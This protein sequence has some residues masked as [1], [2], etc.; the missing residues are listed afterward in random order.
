MLDCSSHRAC[1][2]RTY[3]RGRDAALEHQHGRLMRLLLT[4]EE[5]KRRQKEATERWRI[6]NKDRVAA[7]RAAWKARNPELV[8]ARIA[9]S[10]RKYRASHPEKVRSEA[11]RERHRIKQAKYRQTNRDKVQ[12]YYEANKHLWNFQVSRRRASKRSATPAWA[13]LTAIREI[14]RKCQEMTRAT[15]IKHQVDHIVPLHSRLVCGLHVEHNL[16]V[17]TL[18]EN[19]RKKNKYWPDMPVGG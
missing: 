19:Q 11:E 1:R 9:A 14:H 18:A 2:G 17:I 5:R 13:D 10:T 15:G 4:P 7:V 3:L 6:K 16:R 8:N 12:A